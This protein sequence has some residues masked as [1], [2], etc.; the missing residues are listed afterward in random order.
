MG[1]SKG[2]RVFVEAE[3]VALVSVE[4]VVALVLHVQRCLVHFV[5]PRNRVSVVMVNEDDRGPVVCTSS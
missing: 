3:A 2:W 5:A 4:V 1:G